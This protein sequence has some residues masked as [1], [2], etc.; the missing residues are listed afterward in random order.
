MRSQQFPVLESWQNSRQEKMN[1]RILGQRLATGSIH[2]MSTTF[3]ECL[4]WCLR[5]SVSLRCL[6]CVCVCVCVLG[7]I[8]VQQSLDLNQVSLTQKPVLSSQWSRKSSGVAQPG[9]QPHTFLMW[10]GKPP[11]PPFRRVWPRPDP[12]SSPGPGW[13]SQEPQGEPRFNVL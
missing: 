7:L 5:W 4:L 3:T 1:T 12:G 6:G 11:P 9:P 10:A 2:L 8:S 13:G